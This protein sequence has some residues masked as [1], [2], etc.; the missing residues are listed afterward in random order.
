MQ[1][2]KN[3]YLTSNSVYFEIRQPKKPS[4]LICSQHKPVL[5]NFREITRILLCETFKTFMGL[6]N[7]RDSTENRLEFNNS[8][9]ILVE[10]ISIDDVIH[11]YPFIFDI[12]T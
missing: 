5:S 1:F 4:R 3:K 7:K 2:L 11:C 8:T 6:A 9:Q 12:F 10:F